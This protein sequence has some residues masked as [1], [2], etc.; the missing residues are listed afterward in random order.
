MERNNPESHLLAYWN[1]ALETASTL[2]H[3]K[4]FTKLHLL[5]VNKINGQTY[6][7]FWQLQSNIANIRDNQTDGTL[8]VDL[9]TATLFY[10]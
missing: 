3:D 6:I 8:P 2:A 9:F 10:L 5:L 7:F 4:S 1:R